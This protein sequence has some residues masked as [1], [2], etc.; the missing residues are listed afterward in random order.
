MT[1]NPQKIREQVGEMEQAADIALAAVKAEHGV[2]KDVKSAVKQLH[3][4][5]R[6]AKEG[7][8]GG[9]GEAV[10]D[11]KTTAIASGNDLAALRASIAAAE[12][13]ADQALQEANDDAAV[14]KATKAAIKEAHDAA[15]KAKDLF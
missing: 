5:A 12:E 15:K 8:P 14:G 9:G 1:T 7:L 11:G 13:A 3:D 6:Q 10:D 2:G 4:Y